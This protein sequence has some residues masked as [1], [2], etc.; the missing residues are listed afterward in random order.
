MAIGDAYATLA[1]LKAYAGNIPTLTTTWDNALN[2]A[3]KTASRGIEGV[4]HR[5]FN[6]AGSATARIYHPRTSL[7][8][9][10]DDFQ[11]VTGL[12]IKTDDDNDGVFETT[13]TTADY[14]LDPLNGVRNG[15][16]GWAFEKIRAVGAFS[17]PTSNLRAAV[18]V[19]ARWGWAAV[20]AGV[21]SACLIVAAET[22][23]LKDAPFGV[24]GVGGGPSGG[25]MIMRV[26][27]NPLVM[28]KL[29]DYVLH[30]VAVA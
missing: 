26:R 2:D 20:P 25:D 3:L 9:P 19:T 28:K 4:C 27:E 5:Q 16:P 10:V 18:E 17:F 11:T 14:E 8:T 30:P 29:E 15:V 21:K 12:V 6:D 13:W 1:E 24:A 7:I 22:F 23:K